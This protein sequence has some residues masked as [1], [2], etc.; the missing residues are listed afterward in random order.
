MIWDGHCVSRSL[1]DRDLNDGLIFLPK[2]SDN[3]RYALDWC[4]FDFP[5]SGKKTAS[6]QCSTACGSISSALEM[7]LLNV[8]ASSTYDYCQ[9]P[10]FLPNVGSCASCYQNV[11]NQLFLSN[12]EQSS[13]AKRV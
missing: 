9:D 6:D 10:N 8:T 2:T 1:F 3:M 7:N 13:L 11:P 12:C 5:Q 4:L